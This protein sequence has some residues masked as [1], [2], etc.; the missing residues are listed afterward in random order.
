M[1]RKFPPQTAFTKPPMYPQQMGGM[2]TELLDQNARR[3]YYG[4][5]LFS[6]IS[7][8]PKFANITEY[9]SKIVGIFLDLADPTVERLIHDDQYF[10]Q[11][12]GETVKVK[13]TLILAV[14]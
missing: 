2:P 5:R 10:E 8:N 14:D 13:Y 7:T 12:V 6:K 4:E 3:D 9:F 11:Q 1:L